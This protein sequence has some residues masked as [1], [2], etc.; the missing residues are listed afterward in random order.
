[1]LRV[2]ILRSCGVI[3]CEVNTLSVQCIASVN[4]FV[5]FHVLCY[6]LYSVCNDLELAIGLDEKWK[7]QNVLWY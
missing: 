3:L 2:A 7:D 4:V 1:M 5:I 6:Y